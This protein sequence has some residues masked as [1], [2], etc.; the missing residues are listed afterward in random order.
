MAS[1]HK[2]TQLVVKDAT[3]GNNL[4]TAQKTLNYQPLQAFQRKGFRYK[5]PEG[6]SESP[7]DAYR[8]RYDNLILDSGT[9]Y[10]SSKIV[11]AIRHYELKNDESIESFSEKDQRYLQQSVNPTYENNKNRSDLEKNNVIHKSYQ[12]YYKMKNTKIFQQSVYILEE[13]II[14]IVSLSSLYKELLTQNGS[15]RFFGN[16]FELINTCFS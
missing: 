3:T 1:Y 8:Y 4:H 6:M 16:R 2:S 14:H 15:S 5:V 11:I 12:F 9:D 7:S 13:N 10:F